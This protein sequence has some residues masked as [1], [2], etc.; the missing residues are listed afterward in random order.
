MYPPI[1]K[2]CSSSLAVTAILGASPLRMYQFGLAP[3]LVVKPYATWQT[4]SG[5]PEN[6]L[7]GRPD[8]D[9]FTIQVDIFS[10]TAAEARD[11]AKAIRDAIEL[12]AYVVRWG[13]ESVDPDAKTY[14]VSFD[15]DWIVQR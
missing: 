4:I 15:V 2:V 12:S 14:R 11:A 10:A 7:W 3:Q 6:Y 8:A 13:G 1:F 5:S 9:G